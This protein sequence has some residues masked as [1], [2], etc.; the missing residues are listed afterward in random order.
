MSSWAPTS[1][2]GQL[3]ARVIALEKKLRDPLK[4]CERCRRPRD[5]AEAER[6]CPICKHEEQP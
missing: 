6:L 4:R 2:L 5:N 3:E 1:E